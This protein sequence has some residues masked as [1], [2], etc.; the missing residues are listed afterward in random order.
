MTVF[1]V[2]TAL[3]IDVSQKKRL[4]QLVGSH[5]AL[6]KKRLEQLLGSHKTRKKIRLRAR[7]VL[8]A[9]EGL[10][11]H[12]IARQLGTSRPTVLLWRDRF[13]SLLQQ[14]EVLPRENCNLGAIGVLAYSETALPI[15]LTQLQAEGGNASAACGITS[16][17]YQD[18]K[19]GICPSLVV[20][21]TFMVTDACGNSTSCQQIIS[22][23]RPPRPLPDLSVISATFTAFPGDTSPPE[24]QNAQ[25]SV[26]QKT[27]ALA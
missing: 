25:Q 11:N 2:A 15:T 5:K 16:I 23:V 27:K 13:K 14:D 8:R 19:S 24:T 9:S 26:L 4:E 18:S 3:S 20:T 21:R 6:Q 22:F 10:A 17:T 7:I 12:A 1:K